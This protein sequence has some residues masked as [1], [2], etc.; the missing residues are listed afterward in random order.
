MTQTHDPACNV[1]A[2]LT[3]EITAGGHA[4]DSQLQVIS[5]DVWS[6]V[7]AVPRA[8][9][10]LLGS[11]TAPD[12]PFAPE[13]F[14]TLQPGKP[15][16]IRAGYDGSSDEIFAGVVVTHGIELG[17]DG[18]RVVVDA[19]GHAVPMAASRKTSEAVLRVTYGVS[20]LALKAETEL[21]RSRVAGPRGHV[22]FPGSALA[23]PDCMIE[24]AGV[25]GSFDDR[26]LV[27]A[28]HHQIAYRNWTTSA[29]FGEG[30][31]ALDPAS[32]PAVPIDAVNRMK[33][34]VSE[35]GLELSFDDADRIV[36]IR[37]PRQLVVSLNDTT[38]EIQ[39]TDAN[40]NSVRLGSGGIRIDSMSNLVLAAA[41]DIEMKAGAEL[42]AYGRA[43]ADLT[44]TGIMTV[45]GA[46]VK[47]N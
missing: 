35:S 45:Q 33:S 40:Q 41:G 36:T 34:I 25:G 12:E 7:D 46:L 14:K 28:V 10:V 26:M 16:E 9:V 18:I 19:A 3:L 42:R 6:A 38:G 15:I 22:S 43:A 17:A 1:D 4:L 30:P 32:R 47:I 23:R 37:T 29:E 44:S 5:V 27:C 2:P 13:D 11:G 20:M 24:L 21:R 39:I 8:K 31:Q